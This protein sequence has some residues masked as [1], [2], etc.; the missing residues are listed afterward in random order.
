M[1]EDLP[2]NRLSNW[3][4]KFGYWYV[5]NKLKLKKALI[6]SLIVLNVGLF[7]YAIIYATIIL[8]IQGES[9]RQL[10]NSLTAPL[11]DYAY[12]REK[13]KPRELVL[14]SINILPTTSGRYDIIAKVKNPNSKWVVSSVAYQFVS[15]SEVIAEGEGFIFPSEEKFLIAF[16]VGK[17]VRQSDLI[18]NITNLSWQRFLNFENFAASRLNFDVQNTELITGRKAGTS[19]RLPVSQTRFTVTNNSAYSFWQVGFYVVLYSG[20]NI[21][22]VNYASLEE[23]LSEETREVSINWFESLP[24]ITRIEVIPDVNILD[25]SVY[26]GY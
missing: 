9:F 25:E 5:S 10:Q 24:S 18:L 14:Q 26:I 8:V 13:N 2:S 17:K 16:G 20:S 1:A 11:I 23:F 15:G 19:S 22:G 3:Q 4:L 12:F 21:V 7:G 6:I